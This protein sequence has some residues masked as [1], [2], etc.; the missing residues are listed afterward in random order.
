[1]DAEQCRA[2]R[3]LLNW[4]QADLAAASGVSAVTIRNFEQG[5][6]KPQTASLRV[7]QQ[8]L[9]QAGIQFIPENGGGAGVRFRTPRP[10]SPESTA[11]RD[12]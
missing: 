6:T 12:S 10:L 1:M 8:T 3:G 11:G 7:L 5:K 4:T 2:A 9:E